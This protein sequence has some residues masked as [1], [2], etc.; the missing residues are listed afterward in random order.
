MKEILRPDDEDEDD[1]DSDSDYE[2][3]TAPH[4]YRQKAPR[5][6][7]ERHRAD[8][9]ARTNDRQQPILTFKNV[10]EAL[11]MF[12]GNGDQNIE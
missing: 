3:T 5:D 6:K 4:A 9:K 7:V 12:S 10:E 8:T 2:E 1:S 11:K